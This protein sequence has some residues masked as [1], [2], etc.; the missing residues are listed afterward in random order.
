MRGQD[1]E[2]FGKKMK[3]RAK[4][5]LCQ[6]IIESFHKYDY[7]EC[8]CGEIA[9]DGGDSLKCMANDF[10][11]FVRVDEEGNEIVVTVKPKEEITHVPT[12]IEMLDMLDQMI[13]SIEALPQQAMITPITHYD[14]VSALLLLSSILREDCK[15]SI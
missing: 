12:K 11:N 15:E 4:C 2:V 8:K 9:V 10:N 14:F 6:S 1:K 5:K 7:V 3:N 13:K